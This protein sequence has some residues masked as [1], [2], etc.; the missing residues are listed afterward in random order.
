ML[1]VF[2]TGTEALNSVSKFLHLAATPQSGADVQGQQLASQLLLAI[3]MQRGLLHHL[4][5]WVGLALQ[6][7]A[8]AHSEVKKGVDASYG[9]INMTFF[10]AILAQMID[11][12]VSGHL[13]D[14][15]FS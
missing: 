7:S 12:T 5:D 10:K 9:R 2:L 3:A 11:K 4:L 13:E 1:C 8:S 6:V 15:L 14:D